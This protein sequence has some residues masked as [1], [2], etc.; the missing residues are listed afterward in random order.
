[1]GSLD[2]VFLPNT[3]SVVVR[4][5]Q[6]RFFFQDH[7]VCCGAFLAGAFSFFKTTGSVVVRSSQGFLFV[8]VYVSWPPKVIF[9]QK[10]SFLEHIF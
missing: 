6:G 7:G 1:M 4:C 8:V 10:G 3:G 2:I 9:N 5:S